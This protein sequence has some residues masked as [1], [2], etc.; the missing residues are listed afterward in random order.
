MGKAA[1]PYSKLRHFYFKLLDWEGRAL[2][3]KFVMHAVRTNVFGAGGGKKSGRAFELLTKVFERLLRSKGQGLWNTFEISGLEW[4]SLSN[5]LFLGTCT[6][7]EQVC[8]CRVLELCR[9]ALML[10]F[11]A[12]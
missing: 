1:P 9:D 6:P 3:F 12:T 2:L 5:I 4:S 11:L 7:Q 8:C 10:T